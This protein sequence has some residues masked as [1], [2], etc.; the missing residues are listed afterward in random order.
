METPC[1]SWDLGEVFVPGI[2]GSYLERLSVDVESVGD[3]FI[4]EMLAVRLEGHGEHVFGVFDVSVHPHS[5]P[6]MLDKLA[7]REWR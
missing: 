3:V 1:R 6:H 4:E 5:V 7:G 2:H